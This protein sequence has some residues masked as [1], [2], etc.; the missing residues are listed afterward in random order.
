M[1]SYKWTMKSQQALST[2][3]QSAAT[4]GHPH[5][6]PIH[7]LLALLA[8]TDG[9][10]RPLLEAAGA[11]GP[12]VATQAKAVLDRLPA[13]TGATVAAPGLSRPAIAVVNAAAELASSLGDEYVSTEHL[14]V[15]LAK[16]G[17][18]PVTDLLPAPKA[19]QEAFS[20]VRGS[21]RI[22]SPEPEGA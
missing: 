15:G 11:D 5:V 6:E 16:E 21:T 19:L 22:T 7:L 10:A 12:V 8:Q 2:A 1:N 3:V 4:A 13:A 17:G 18:S 9:I 20:A 14:V